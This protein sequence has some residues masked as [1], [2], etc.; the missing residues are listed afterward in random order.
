MV[1]S[2]LF[3]PGIICGCIFGRLTGEWVKHLTYADDLTTHAVHPGIY[4]LL[5][6]ACMLGGMSRMTIS[7][8][9][10]LV[11][12]TG[13]IQYLFPIMICLMISKSV[14]D[15]FNISL[16]DLH[17]KL[18][19]LPFVEG[20]PPDHMIRKNAINVATRS[21]FS[22]PEV[23]TVQEVYEL[24]RETNHCGFPVR[25]KENQLSG[26]VLRSQLIVL[27]RKRNVRA[28]QLLNCIPSRPL[29]SDRGIACARTGN[30]VLGWQR[31]VCPAA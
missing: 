24:L 5:G 31:W 9:I 3:V 1:P 7:M 23:P 26:I 27:L 28:S 19:C 25:T 10:I 17:M 8:S 14:G 6:A 15:R 18:K 20:E 13:N 2:G 21:V 22:L 30:V 12:T 16:Y 4:A 29:L 11:E